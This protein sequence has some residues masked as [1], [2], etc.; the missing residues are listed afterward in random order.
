MGLGK[1]LTMISLF[2]KAKE[3]GKADSGDSVSENVPARSAE[4][5]GGTLVVC[6]ASLINQW[7]SELERRTR[8]GL[9]SYEIY[10]GQ[11]RETKPK[12]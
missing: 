1:T 10:H 12:R 2:L 9:V 11:R 5:N 7:S 4:P 8:R 3:M 6:P